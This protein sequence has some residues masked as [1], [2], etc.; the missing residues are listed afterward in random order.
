MTTPKERFEI[1]RAGVVGRFS[2]KPLDDDLA[3]LVLEFDA[4]DGNDHAGQMKHV[5]ACYGLAMYCAQ[6]LEVGL[7]NVGVMLARVRHEVSLQDVRTYAEGFASRTL[8]QMIGELR[9][10]VPLDTYAERIIRIALK[11][12]NALAHHYFSRRIEL[13]VH[14]IG[15]R[16]LTSELARAAQLF[17]VADFV[18]EPTVQLL[19]QQFNCTQDDVDRWVRRERRRARERF[20]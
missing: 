20:R 10:L 9:T 16:W 18:F 2:F 13:T 1:T 19:L 15:R 8:G 3:R 5:Y 4:L 6:V 17:R 11:K 7:S 12:R 14:P